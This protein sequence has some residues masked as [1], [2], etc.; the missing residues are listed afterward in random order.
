[1]HRMD[2]HGLQ[3]TTIVVSSCGDS[4]FNAIGCLVEEDFDV[5]TLHLYTV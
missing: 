4:L 5:Q 2:F 1:M 3:L